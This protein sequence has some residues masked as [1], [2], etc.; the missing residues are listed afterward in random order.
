MKRAWLQSFTG[1]IIVE[2]SI[3]ILSF[4]K[5]AERLALRAVD[6]DQAILAERPDF[7]SQVFQPATKAFRRRGIH[8]VERRAGHGFLA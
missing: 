6:I 8:Q 5:A 7:R 1:P 2:T 3:G 4:T